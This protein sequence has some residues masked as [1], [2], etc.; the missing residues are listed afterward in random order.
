MATR[1]PPSRKTA[2]PSTARKKTPPAAAPQVPEAPAALP[3]DEPVPP[4]RRTAKPKA[5]AAAAPAPAPASRA[6][7]DDDSPRKAPKRSARQAL[8]VNLP[9]LVLEVLAAPP[10]PAPAKPAPAKKAVAKKAA[11]KTVAAAKDKSPAKAAA[12]DQPKAAKPAAPAAPAASAAPTKG[13]AKA[14][15]APAPEA[16]PAPAA[17]ALRRQ[18]SMADA[19][20]APVST[21]KPRGKAADQAAEASPPAAPPPVLVAPEVPAAVPEVDQPADQPA[22]RPQRSRQRARAEAAAAPAAESAE[23]IAEAGAAPQAVEAEA[24]Q[25]PARQDRQRSRQEGHEGKAPSSRGER[26]RRNERQGPAAQTAERPTGEAP[27]PVAEPA[28]PPAPPAP[29][30]PSDLRPPHSAVLL[31]PNGRPGL[32]WQAGKTCPPELDQLARDAQGEDGLLHL[33]DDA[34]LPQLIRGAR[35]AQHE[36]RIAPDLWM[37]LAWHRDALHRLH[38]LEHAYPQGPASAALRQLLPVPLA[39]YQAE[40][41]LF[42]VCAGR[43]LIADEPGL[44]K[45]A[46]AV[47]AAAL[48]RRHVGIDRV[49]VLCADAAVPTWEREWL[50]FAGARD[51]QATRIVGAGKLDATGAA[52]LAAWAPD[53]VVIDEPQRLGA[54][55]A[56]PSRHA[57]VLCGANDDCDPALLQSIVQYLDGPRRAA[58][59][60]FDPS[61]R[62]QLEAAM[63]SL[64]LQRSRDEVRAQLPALVPSAR[65]VPMAP[66][67]RQAHDQRAARA[68]ELLARWRRTGLLPDLDQVQLDQ[69]VRELQALCHRDSANGPLNAGTLAALRALVDELLPAGVTPPAEVA[70][71][72]PEESDLDTVTA[73]LGER[74]GLAVVASV[75]DVPDEAAVLVRIGV[76][77]RPMRG[78]R[79]LALWRC[80][81]LVAQ[82]GFDSGLYD[83]LDGRRDTPRGMA[84]EARGFLSGERLTAYLLAVE[85]AL[86]AMQHG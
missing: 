47:A 48:M 77:W 78:A 54:W 33:D 64:A 51:V 13:R 46:Q 36:L 32:L 63:A 73:L 58:A 1:T 84:E 17:K 61:E 70:V 49:L 18:S 23:S 75:H 34:V 20:A 3:A 6:P 55:S 2:A 82:R 11:A 74:E 50:R 83:T 21:R 24:P 56:I 30:P 42:A 9:E 66:A 5:A 65:V 39:P 85:A 59:W 25:Q 15:P 53:L 81:H 14:A 69:D 79:D 86:T 19:M 76:P 10:A 57:L 26:R 7:A 35:E 71:C 67:Q 4:R 31:D 41:A 62:P 16:A 43:A 37:Q 38:A 45:T 22:D 60:T 52:A 80:I 68:T 8:P 12:A 40:G 29:P 72:C 28:T 44:G 27:I